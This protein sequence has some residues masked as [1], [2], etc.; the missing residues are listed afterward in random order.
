M[1]RK[2]LIALP[3]LAL[4]ACDDVPYVPG[5]PM[6]TMAEKVAAYDLAVAS[7][8]CRMIGESDYLAVEFQADL[9]REESVAI[10][11]AKLSSGNAERLEDGGVLVTNGA[12][13][14]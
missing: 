4:A 6:Q 5:V 1:I 11:E 7:I 12:C 10:T 13:A 8:G 9:T 2:T 14:A 3:F